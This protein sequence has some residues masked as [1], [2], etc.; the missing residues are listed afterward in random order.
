MRFSE[1]EL[2]DPSSDFKSADE[3]YYEEDS[4]DDF[5][6]GK[7]VGGK[8]TIKKGGKLTV[9]KASNRGKRTIT[10]KRLSRPPK[11]TLKGK[12]SCPKPSN[13]APKSD[14]VDFLCEKCGEVFTS[15]WALGGHAS[16]VH[17]G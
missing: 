13:A 8:A 2:K 9:V 6:L 1:A 3:S 12:A 11:K 14:G 10:K 16:R 17:P 4:D 5:K 7:R 15:G